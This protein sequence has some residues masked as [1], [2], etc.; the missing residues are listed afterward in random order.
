MCDDT[1]RENRMTKRTGTWLGMVLGM[2]I[3][4]H[5]EQAWAPFH[6]VV[7]EEVFFGTEDCPNAQYVKLRTIAFG[8]TLVMGQRMRTQLADG[9]AAAD[10]GRFT[11]NLTNSASGVAMIMGTAEAEGLFG[12]TFDEVVTGRLVQPDGRVC[13]ALFGP[14]TGPVDCVAYGNYTG[15]NGK[16]GSPTV[17][18]VLGMALVRH[19]ETNDNATDFALGAP[20]PENNNGDMGTL[21]QCSS[22]ACTGDCDGDFIVTVDEIVR[23]V[24]IALGMSTVVGCERFDPDA[25]GTVTVDEVV[26]AVDN[27]LNGCA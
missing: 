9:T 12:M 5:A 19:S 20:N 25:S 22:A 10:F 7:I 11:K 26:T 14:P 3:L 27:A 15:D 2:A 4:L 8:Q 21:G 23:G 13:W 17:A 16:S 24:N 18:P 6:L 1:D